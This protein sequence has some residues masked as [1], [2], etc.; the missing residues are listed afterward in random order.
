MG[1]ARERAGIIN[2]SASGQPGRGERERERGV[3]GGKKAFGGGGSSA[4]V[5]DDA[6]ISLLYRHH[7]DIPRLRS[8]GLARARHNSGRRENHPPRARECVD[9]TK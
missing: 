3:F 9:V 4:L 7:N 5:A 1:R 6:M 2:P 8:T